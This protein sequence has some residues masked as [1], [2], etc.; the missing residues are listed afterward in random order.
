M[1]D[2]DL[3]PPLL[4]GETNNGTLLGDDGND[5]SINFSGIASI[6]VFY[7]AVLAVGVWAGWKQR[8]SGAETNQ[9]EIML[10]GRNIGL[11]VGVLTMGG[12]YVCQQISLA[13]DL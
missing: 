2:A 11:G 13:G 1:S 9:E 5:R 10:A 7:L 8:R 4:S 6:V 3:P 12:T